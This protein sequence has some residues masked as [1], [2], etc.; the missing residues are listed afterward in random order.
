MTSYEEAKRDLQTKPRTW[1]ITGVAGFIGSNLLEQLLRLNQ[2]VV[3]LDNFSTGKR[4]NLAEV[5]NL[6]TPLQWDRFC[7]ME[8]DIRNI[9]SCRE[10]CRGVDVILHQ[11][12]LGSVP[13]SIEDPLH[14]N[15][16]NVTGSLNMLLAARD[17]KVKR[18]V[19]AASSAAYGD[20][21]AH[22]KIEPEVGKPLSPYA[23]S[24]YVNEL[25]AEVFS[26]LYQLETI[27]LRYFNVFGPRQNPHGAYA[28]VIPRWIAAMINA[29]PVYIIGTGETN[30]DYCYVENV[31]QI[32]VLAA[33]TRNPNAINQIYNAAL[34]ERTTLNELFDKLRER[35]LPY[36]SHL[37]DCKPAYRDFRKGDVRHSQADINKARRLLGY[38]PSHVIDQG[39]D[40]AIEWYMRGFA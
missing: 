27:G 9:A 36:Y 12:A 31:V 35:L 17:M 4:E 8:G 6:V 21:Q 29:E 5:R 26:R 34:N 39:L 11:A 28:A 2:H 7:L 25:Y 33:T 37:Q 16:N 20:H 38:S 3:G 22:P 24:K 32:N 15:E 1:L 14:C 30:R 10:A 40:S 19:Y 13:R 23:V 18:I